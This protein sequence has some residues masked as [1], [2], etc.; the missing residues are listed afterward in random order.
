M[1]TIISLMQTH[2]EYLKI[3]TLSKDLKILY[4][5]VFYRAHKIDYLLKMVNLLTTMKLPKTTSTSKME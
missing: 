4:M 2:L 5:M 1:K 3:V